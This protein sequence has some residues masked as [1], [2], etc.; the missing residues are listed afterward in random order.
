MQSIVPEGMSPPLSN[1]SHAISVDVGDSTLIF[2][3]GVIAFEDGRVVGEDDVRRQTEFCYG[4]LQRMLEAAG[5]S[6]ADVVKTNTFLTD[7]A[8]ISEVGEARSGFLGDPPPTSTTVGVTALARPG[9]L[10]E[11]EAI[12]VARKHG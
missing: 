1:Y 4:Q 7:M 12:A 8:R 2:L 6:F 11:V 9:C 10:V 5:A 3:A